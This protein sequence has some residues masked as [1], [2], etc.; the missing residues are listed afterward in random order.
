MKV[1][2]DMIDRACEAMWGKDWKE[3]ANEAW[4]TEQR[5][6]MR[7]A[8]EAALALEGEGPDP[9]LE[10]MARAYEAANCHPPGY[11]A[12]AHIPALAAARDALDA[13]R[14]E[15]HRRSRG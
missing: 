2:A 15:R 3:D 12:E 4:L 11:A 5:S 13:H 6:H 14:A 9:E 7:K 8:L 1:T 10:V